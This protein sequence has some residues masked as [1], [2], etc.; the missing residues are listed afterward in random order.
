METGQEGSGDEHARHPNVTHLSRPGD[1]R[2]ELIADVTNGLLTEPRT[3]PSKY[4]YDGR[5]SQLFDDITRL[6][7]YYLGRDETEILGRKANEIITAIQPDEVVELGSGY[8]VK[9]KLILDAMRLAGRGTRYVP[10]DISESAL[11]QASGHLAAY[12]PWL[13]IDGYVGDFF[14]DLAKVPHRGVRLV[15]FLGSTIGN[16][17][18]ATRQEVLASVAGMLDEGD[19]LLVGVDLVKAE[20]VLLAAYDDAAGVTAEFNRNMLLVINRELDANFPLDAFTYVAT[21]DPASNCVVMGLKAD[22]DMMVVIGALNTELHLRRDEVIHNEVSC[23]FTEA[24]VAADFEQAGLALEQWHTGPRDRYA[25]ALG[26][27]AH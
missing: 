17:D 3:M 22:R 23:K 13:T 12:Y 24:V 9:T 14:T 15:T 21:W 16:F 6:P 26:I 2:T 11:R 20:A 4:F 1:R 10:I 7:E 25:L 19:G 18:Y 27:P 5:G 8:S